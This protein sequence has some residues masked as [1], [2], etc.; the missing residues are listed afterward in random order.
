[1]SR[2]TNIL[3]I[4]GSD[5][6]GGAGIQADVRVAML[7]GVNAATAVTAVTVQNS[8][9]FSEAGA[10]SA[11]SLRRQIEAVAEDISIDAV[12]VGMVPDAALVAVIAEAIERFGLPNVVID[13]VGAPT[14]A[15]DDSASAY[16]A[17]RSLLIPKG[18]VITP[19][20]SEA[21]RL[22]D[23]DSDD[24][25]YDLHI[26]YGVPT[27][28]VKGGDVAGDSVSDL[29]YTDSPRQCGRFFASKISTRATHGTGCA[30][31]TAIACGLA[32]GKTPLRAIADAERL[33]RTLIKAGSGYTHGRGDYGPL[34]YIDYL[35]NNLK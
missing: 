31:S 1:M 14:V 20:F 12:K 21:R 5:C 24:P 19:N 2:Y 26:K 22:L 6:S 3:S 4:G 10:V 7:C 8:Q 16:D 23:A 34:G 17:L 29:F 27:V 13:P 11:E 35:K 15:A 33:V 18:A 25:A 32:L 30:L 9:R 28:L